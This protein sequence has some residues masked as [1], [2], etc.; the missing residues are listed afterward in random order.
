MSLAESYAHPDARWSVTGTVELRTSDGKIADGF[1]ARRLSLT[2]SG[3]EVIE[4]LARVDA[5][6]WRFAVTGSKDTGSS[7]MDIDVRFDGVPLGQ[8]G[9]KLSGHRTLPIGADR[10]IAAGTARAYGGCSIPVPV[11]VPVPVPAL[12]PVLVLFLVRRRRGSPATA[13]SFIS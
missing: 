6:L 12:L 7:W 2:T 3:G 1:D 4:P 5:G 11:P 9:T 10:W 13:R 8:P